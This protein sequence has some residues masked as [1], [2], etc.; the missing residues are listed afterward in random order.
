MNIYEKIKNGDY[1]TKLPYPKRPN[2]NC[3][4]C[5]NN[6]ST[7]HGNIKKFC[8]DCGTPVQEEYESRLKTYQKILSEYK[9]DT[10]RLHNLFKTDALSYCEISNHKKADVAFRIAMTERDNNQNIVEFLEELTEL[11]VD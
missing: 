8:A 7:S 9:D 6:C 2:M 1:E 4:K 3:F 5:G 10:R 11:M